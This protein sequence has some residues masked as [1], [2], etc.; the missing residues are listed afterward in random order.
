MGRTEEALEAAA[1]ALRLKPLVVDDHL[2][3]VGAAYD[4]AGTA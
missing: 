3:S 2:D 4:M 1:Q